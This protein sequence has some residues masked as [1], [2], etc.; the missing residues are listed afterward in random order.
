MKTK[1]LFQQYREHLQNEIVQIDDDG[2]GQFTE[3]YIEVSDAT[4]ELEEMRKAL[5]EESRRE[6]EDGYDSEY[7]EL[8]VRNGGTTFSYKGLPDWE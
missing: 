6:I 5:Y 1:E 7:Y 4:K 3:L 8:Q 2:F